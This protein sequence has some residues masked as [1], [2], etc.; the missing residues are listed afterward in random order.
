MP[1]RDAHR[2]M[3]R[4][5]EIEDRQS[6]MDE[7][8]ACFLA[9]AHECSLV[10]RPAVPQRTAHARQ[11]RVQVGNVRLIF[12]NAG[13]AAHKSKFQKGEQDSYS[14]DV[15]ARCRFRSG[16]EARKGSSPATTESSVMAVMQR[17]FSTM[18]SFRKQF[19]HSVRCRK[20]MCRSKSGSHVPGELRALRTAATG[21]PTAAA[22]C[23]GPV[24]LPNQAAPSRQSSKISGTVNDSFGRRRS[25]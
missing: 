19:S 7:T 8:A 17:C 21:Q 25:G 11:Q 6:R 9:R 18:H 4:R 5:T 20:M 14:H 1:F 10:V 15:A 13:D 22:T 23:I 2:L 12:K 16:S 24:S 3:A